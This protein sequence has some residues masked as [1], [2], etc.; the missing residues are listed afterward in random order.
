MN[1]RWVLWATTTAIGASALTLAMFFPESMEGSPI[2]RSVF[3]PG[4]TTDGH[5]QIEVS[6]ETC[7]TDNFSDRSEMQDACVECH[8]AELERADD[9]HPLSKFTDPRNADRVEIL[10]ARLCITCH[11][12][13]RPEVTSTMGLSLPGDYCYQCHEKVGEERPTHRDLA[14]DSCA[15][16][17]CHNFH[18]NKALYEDFLVEHRNEPALK[19]EGFVPAIAPVKWALDTALEPL[20]PDEQDAP[21]GV[22]LAPEGLA[23]W[24]ASGHAMAG[25]NCSDCHAP[26]Q[27]AWT[28]AP[29]RA[30]CNDCHANAN[31]GFEAGRHGMR[32][33]ADLSPMQ[34]HLARLPMHD[35]AGSTSLDCNACHSAHAYDTQTAAVESCLGCHA[36]DHSLAYRDSKHFFAW[37]AELAGDAPPGSGVSCA[38]CHL[39]RVPTPG[40]NGLARVAHNQNDFLR[41]NEKMIRSVCMDCHGLPFSIDSL[42]DP[43]LIHTN[44]RGQPS[45]KIESIHYASTLRWELEGKAPPWAD[46]KQ[47]E[48]EE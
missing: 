40:A 38:T 7:H 27:A 3:L 17:G 41:P 11:Q 5:Y 39:P 37:Q 20:G 13:H 19:A 14:F 31:D 15:S 26:Q 18:D 42:A 1:W 10:D 34:P 48:N 32:L 24:S 43:A 36:D 28:D 33:A 23:D 21:S 45:R 44:F 4:D 8:S 29:E 47:Q 35:E 46:A 16:A 2:E 12:E 25:V 30:V 6:C 9:S 22:A